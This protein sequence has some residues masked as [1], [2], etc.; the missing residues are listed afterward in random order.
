MAHSINYTLSHHVET[1]EERVWDDFR[2]RILSW[3][4]L[5]G[6]NDDGT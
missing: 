5:P 3:T 4:G 6:G 2:G 1:D